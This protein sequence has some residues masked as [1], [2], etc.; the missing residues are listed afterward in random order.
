MPPN[1]VTI[2]VAAKASEARLPQA[3]TG[4]RPPVMAAKTLGVAPFRPRLAPF[5]L[6]QGAHEPCFGAS[7]HAHLPEGG[8]GDHQKCYSKRGNVVYNATP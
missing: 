1:P 6:P 8:W 4:L 2:G 3:V 5:G 7:L